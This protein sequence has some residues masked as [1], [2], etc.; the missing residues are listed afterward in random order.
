MQTIRDTSGHESPAAAPDGRPIV[1]VGAGVAGLAAARALHD[2]GLRVRVLEARDRV[3]GRICTAGVGDA[4]VDLGAAWFHGVE[5]NPVADYARTRGLGLTL[6]E[7]GVGVFVDAALDRMLAGAAAGAAFTGA[8]E[9]L[10]GLATRLGPSGDAAAGPAVED[11]VANL[12]APAAEARAVRF[13]AELALAVNAAPLDR[14]SLRGLLSEGPEELAGG[15]HVVDGGYRTVVDALSRELDIA[16]GTPVTRIAHSSG[17]VAVEA[18]GGAV[19]ASHAIVTAPLGVLKAGS[20]AFDPALPPAKADAIGRL[21]HGTFEK[22]MLVFA[23]RFWGD[24]LGGGLAVL[25]GFGGER[26]FPLFVDLTRF[27]RPR[28]SCAS[29]RARSRRRPRPRWR[30]KN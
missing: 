3:G 11:C 4:V 25:S 10:G 9:V 29:T 27:A 28:R 30:P 23:E 6:Y 5:G 12:N 19:D 7:A 18:A 13:A 21:G 14:L 15:D 24:A 16:L 17:G 2:A 22:V 26:A 1:V 8:R 20:I